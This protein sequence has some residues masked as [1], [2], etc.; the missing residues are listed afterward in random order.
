MLFEIIPQHPGSVHQCSVI[1]L[2][3]WRLTPPSFNNISILSCQSVLLVEETEV[4]LKRGS[5]MNPRCSKFDLKKADQLTGKDNF[6]YL[7]LRETISYHNQYV[8]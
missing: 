4:P 5:M 6:F 1:G 8:R 3:S 2:G 7:T